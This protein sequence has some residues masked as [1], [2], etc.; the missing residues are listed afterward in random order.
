MSTLQD[1]LHALR[2]MPCAT[3]SHRVHL[4]SRTLYRDES[5]GP[6]VRYHADHE[7]LHLTFPHECHRL[8]DVTFHTGGKAVYYKKEGDVIQEVSIV[9]HQSIPL[10]PDLQ[11]TLY[12]K[13][14]WMISFTMLLV[15]P[16][17]RL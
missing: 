3:V 4:T 12:T 1:S 16:Q 7:T 8:L 15:R 9:P 11:L 6:Y 17:C 2:D 13:P 14:N 5:Y 10:V